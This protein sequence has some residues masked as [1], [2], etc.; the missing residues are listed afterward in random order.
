LCSVGSLMSPTKKPK[1]NVAASS[2]K[3]PKTTALRSFVLPVATRSRRGSPKHGPRRTSG[4]A[5][6]PPFGMLLSFM[7]GTVRHRFAG[8]SGSSGVSV[9]RIS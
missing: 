2:M 6:R 7:G 5:G 8:T 3:K 1:S 4:H 9:G